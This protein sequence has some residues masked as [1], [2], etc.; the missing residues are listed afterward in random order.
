SSRVLRLSC[1]DQISPS[2]STQNSPN[3]LTFSDGIAGLH[4][5]SSSPSFL[6]WS[7]VALR[8]EKGDGLEIRVYREIDVRPQKTVERSFPQWSMW[9]AKF[10]ADLFAETQLIRDPSSGTTIN[11][12]LIVATSNTLRDRSYLIP[13]FG[14]INNVTR[15]SLMPHSHLVP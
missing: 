10:I 9:M 14:A 7:P 6:K 2:N 8:L 11:G 1:H 3:I 13:L 15:Q 12:Y 5:L 4:W